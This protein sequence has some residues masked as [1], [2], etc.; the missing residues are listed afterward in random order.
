MPAIFIGINA[1]GRGGRVI[2]VEPGQACYRCIAPE[3]YEDNTEEFNLNGETGGLASCQLIDN[4]A[5][6]VIISYLEEG[7]PSEYGNKWNS[8]Y[9][10]CNEILIQL[11]HEHELRH[12]WDV[13]HDSENHIQPDHRTDLEKLFS[14]PRFYTDQHPRDENCQCCSV[15]EIK[16][17]KVTA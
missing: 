6:D 9:N 10:R 3:R 5:L 11:S 7:E 17:F 8:M 12:M 15:K 16:N 14:A 4:L 2:F 1:G 13:I